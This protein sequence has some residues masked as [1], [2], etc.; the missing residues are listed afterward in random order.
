[1]VHEKPTPRPR[2]R[3]RSARLIAGQVSLMRRLV[4]FVALVV[5]VSTLGTSGCASP[6][7]A[8]KEK[9]AAEDAI[10]ALLRRERLYS[11]HLTTWRAA[12]RPT[13]GLQV[14]QSNEQPGHV[15][16][17]ECRVSVQELLRASSRCSA[18]HALLCGLTSNSQWC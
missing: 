11:S 2:G 15:G 7:Q 4:P 1:M 14:L 9:K 17:V 8:E 18:A 6:P 12:L 10:G 13:L 5:L 16:R 3:F